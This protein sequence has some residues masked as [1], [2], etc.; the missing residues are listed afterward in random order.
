MQTSPASSARWPT[1]KAGSA[2][3]DMS[4]LLR[5]TAGSVDDGKSTLGACSM[6]PR[7]SSR[8]SSRRSSA[9]RERGDEYTNLALL[10]DGAS[11]TSE[12]AS[13]S[14]WPTA[15]SPRRPARSS[16]ATRP[17]HTQYT[18]NMATGAST[19][20]LAVVL[21]DARTGLVEQTRTHLVVA[22]TLGIPHLVLSVN[23]MDLVDWSEEV[24]DESAEFGPSSGSST[25]TTSPPSPSRRCTATTSSSRPANSPWYEGPT[26]APPPRRGRRRPPSTGGTDARFPVQLVI[27]PT[28]TATDPALRGHRHRRA[29]APRRRRRGPAERRSLSRWRRSRRGW[30]LDEAVAPTAVTIRLAD[31][32]DISRG[33]LIARPHNRPHVGQD[34]DATVCWM[35]E[36]STLRAGEKYTL[37]HT[38][39]TV[40]A[41]V[42]DLTYRLDVNTLH[43]DETSPS[44][45]S[46][47]SAGCAFA[48][49]RHLLRRVPP[50]P[51]HGE[52]HPRRRHHERDPSRR[53]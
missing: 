53:G 26:R 4:E 6:T 51:D 34:V 30:P 12:A 41:L 1:R 43:R 27:R 13:P 35:D 45:S 17:G 33:D 47:R 9:P 16:S 48:P 50:Q 5:A 28:T 52:L 3:T 11:R 19:A 24:F 44:C 38:T 18:R 46:T 25:S 23:K 29:A 31:D 37:K 39:R 40:K 49:R 20:D 7:R 21:V 42:R 14:T 10:T 32:I 2:R 8:T 22:A 15:T 36:R